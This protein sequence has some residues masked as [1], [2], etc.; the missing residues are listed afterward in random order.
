M[1][2]GILIISKLLGSIWG[3]E[4]T[5]KL[6]EKIEFLRFSRNMY[7]ELLERAHTIEEFTMRNQLLRQDLANLNSKY[8]MIKDSSIE[9]RK[10][11]IASVKTIITRFNST[12][13]QIPQYTEMISSLSAKYTL[14][15][16]QEER[17]R[18]YLNF[19]IEKENTKSNI[20]D[21]LST[22]KDQADGIKDDYD[23]KVKPLLEISMEIMAILG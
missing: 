19:K 15:G 7:D 1:G 5:K 14:Q 9:T 6:E 10:I 18:K 17:I 12:L 23:K 8:E 3:N 4:T 20:Q 13:S 22:L 21:V 16:K 11:Y 2:A